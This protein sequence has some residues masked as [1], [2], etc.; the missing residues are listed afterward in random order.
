MARYINNPETAEEARTGY[1]FITQSGK[2]TVLTDI[3]KSLSLYIRTDTKLPAY[4]MSVGA[5]NKNI[6]YMEFGDNDNN[7]IGYTE[8]HSDAATPRSLIRNNGALAGKVVWDKI[9][10]DALIGAILGG[11]KFPED[12]VL[13][14]PE[15]CIPL[16]MYKPTTVSVNGNEV[17]YNTAI[18]FAKGIYF[19]VQRNQSEDVITVYSCEQPPS[20]NNRDEMNQY[21]GASGSSS[22]DGVLRKISWR[23]IE[24][25]PNQQ[26]EV[27]IDASRDPKDVW[28]KSQATCDL[29][30][31]TDYDTIIIKG[32]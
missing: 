10:A 29:R 14:I 21:G 1:P 26:Q 13:V 2:T 9:A 3:V 28:I 20:T 15:V 11:Y 17:P 31:I 4:I 5:K 8:Y 12:R 7:S 22:V 6:L 25:V 18:S 30:V 16:Y 27:S 24:G 32:V 23:S 19:T